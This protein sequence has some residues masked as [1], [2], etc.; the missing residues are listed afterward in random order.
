MGRVLF[1][2]LVEQG[3]AAAI[4]LATGVM[5]VW[6]LP[7]A[8]HGR[9][10]VMAVGV[11]AGL[12]VHVALVLDPLTVRG[13]ARPATIGAA[14][15]V[16]M[17]VSALCGLFAW[18]LPGTL[19][20]AAATGAFGAAGP[21]VLTMARRVAHLRRRPME[22][23]A[24]VLAAAVFTA[25]LAIGARTAGD[26]LF[27]LSLGAAMG[28]APVLA[29]AL[30]LPG[31]R[32]LAAMTRHPLRLGGW[33]LVS[34]GPWVVSTQAPLIILASVQGEGAAGA[35]RGL[36]LLLAPVAH[37]AAA[38]GTVVQPRLADAAR[39]G[40]VRRTALGWGG[41]I[42]LCAMP[43]AVVLMMEPDMVARTVLGHDYAA[44]AAAALPLLA[45]GALLG[46]LGAGPALALRAA[47]R[48]RAIAVAS[49]AGAV[50][51][52]GTAFVLVPGMGVSGAAVALL[53]ARG[54]DIA[55]QLLLLSQPRGWRKREAWA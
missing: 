33:L 47:R 25:M 42:G 52:V 36:V 51:G 45:V 17:A 5:A 24:A 54:A 19:A 43:W 53:A 27:A 14:A 29:R 37:I 3:V 10:A 31:R 13:R 35:L 23:I 48:G 2:A 49:S 11:S 26:F 16:L 20:G 34:A 8:E 44:A 1:A 7:I 30:C 41:A 32:V 40:D 18:S 12:A 4:P 28:G 22:A 6:T 9:L 38:V 50:A 39:Q 21:A 46:A 55:V 15:V